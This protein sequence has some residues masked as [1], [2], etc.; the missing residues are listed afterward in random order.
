MTRRRLDAWKEIA[1]YLGRDVTTVRRWEKRE[2]LPVHR[3]LHDKLGSVYAFA[4]EVD[5]WTARRSRQ[6]IAPCEPEAVQPAAGPVPVALPAPTVTDHPRSPIWKVGLALT[7]TLALLLAATTSPWTPRSRTGMYRFAITPPP[8]TVVNT[9]ALSPDGTQVLFTAADSAGTRIWIRR[10]D[11]T[12]AEPLPGTDGATF[13]FWSPD[14]QQ[15]GFFADEALKVFA[16]ATREVRYLAPAREGHGGTWNERGDILFAPD[17]GAPLSHVMASGSQVKVVT[18]TGTTFKEGHAWPEFLPDGRHFL[19]TDYTAD[20]RRYGIYVGDLRTGETRRV[21]RVYS[22]ASYSPEGY[23][24]YVNDALIMQPFDLARMEVLGE[25]RPLADHVLQRYDLGHQADFSVARTGLIAVRSAG[26]D[27][28]QLR[29]FD[30]R[31]GRP[32]GSLGRPA[33]YSNP[34]LSPDGTQLIT[35][36]T[37]VSEDALD[38]NLW[39][40]NVESGQATRISFGSP[41]DFA[42][43]WWPRQSEILFATPRGLFRQDAAGGHPEQVLRAKMQQMPES[44]S[45]DGRYLTVQAFGRTTKSDIWVWRLGD[46]IHATPLL[47]TQANEGQSQIS[48]DGRYLAYASDE[49]GRFEIYVQTFPKA[50]E[51]WQISAEG[52][53]DPRWRG[54]GREL[55]Y[56]AAD[57]RMMTVDTTIQP[58]FR[59]GGAK[60]LFQTQLESLW[61]D[62]RNHYD[63]TADG[64]RFVVIAPVSDRREAPFTFL[65]NWQSKPVR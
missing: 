64:K 15:F 32:T 48:P 29:W 54:D 4:D 49:S 20:Q 5:E 56:I 3:H 34:T 24:L 57:R 11:S 7:A 46:H 60:V 31:T 17:R 65:M 23:L 21:L 37:D 40:F 42:P 52:G 26:R 13:P 45:A 36:V 63:V 18:T 35:T 50:T 39:S 8:G 1:S 44:W 28:L 59:H 2:G 53:A 19:Y 58:L 41:V 61:M 47:N 10:V 62:T 14:G 12:E 27:L 9:L 6:K 38:A 16:I 33:W 43:L 51:R 55:F 22:N 25:P 30:R